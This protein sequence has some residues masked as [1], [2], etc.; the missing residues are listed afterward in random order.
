MNERIKE[1]MRESGV[2]TL[3]PGD[4]GAGWQGPK[5][6]SAGLSDTEKLEKFA[7]LIVKE[8]AK[9]ANDNFDKGFCPVGD[10]IKEHFGVEE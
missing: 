2:K 1:L 6:V 3:F 8:C 9:V 4:P 10:F 5:G 7:E